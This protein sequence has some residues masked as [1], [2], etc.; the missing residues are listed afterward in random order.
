MSGKKMWGGRFAAATD[1]LVEGYTQSVSFDHRLYAEDIAG[2]KAHAR[3]LAAQGIIT[4]D[5][6]AALI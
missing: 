1:A 5:E 6:A 3:M 2:S 4:R